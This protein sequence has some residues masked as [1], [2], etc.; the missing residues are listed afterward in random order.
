MVKGSERM[1]QKI[2]KMEIKERVRKKLKDERFVIGG[3]GKGHPYSKRYKL[4]YT[5]E[6]IE[7]VVNALMDVLVDIIEDGDTAIMD[8]YFKIEP[9]LSVERKH[10]NLYS[11]EIY[12]HPA[13]YIFKASAGK[14]L[15][16]ACKR[17]SEKTLNETTAAHS[18]N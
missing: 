18:E 7:K 3:N 15:K 14:H 5:K 12:V 9:S 2:N 1:N 17:L 16:E 4:R 11:R 13:H 10:I 8:G 6:I